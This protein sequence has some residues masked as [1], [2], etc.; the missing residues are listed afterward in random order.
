[1]LFFNTNNEPDNTN[2]IPAE[3]PETG[4]DPRSEIYPAIRKMIDDFKAS[5]ANARSEAECAIHQIE[6]SIESSGMKEDAESLFRK[7]KSA[8]KDVYHRAAAA[9]NVKK[10]EAAA[11]FDTEL[12]DEEE[13]DNFNETLRRMTADDAGSEMPEDGDMQALLH[14]ALELM[15]EIP[16]NSTFT[17]DPEIA[18]IEA[19]K[20]RI[21]CETVQEMYRQTLEIMSDRRRE[22]AEQAEREQKQL[23]QRDRILS[24]EEDKEMR[25][26]IVDKLYQ[27]GKITLD[28]YMEQMNNTITFFNAEICKVIEMM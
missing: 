21:Q 1:M 20:M 22:A 2:E 28:A 19:N 27:E 18:A 3:E 15:Q 23:Y 26:R 5:I 17:D 7:T 25:M 14:R 24:L 9:I 16:G 6:E 11:G 13:S 10:E 4:E 8:I 12:E